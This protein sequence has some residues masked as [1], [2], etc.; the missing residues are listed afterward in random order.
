MKKLNNFTM[1][2]PDR[3]PDGRIRMTVL[4]ALLTLSSFWG[5]A[6]TTFTNSGNI[7]VPSSGNANPYPSNI[8]V[9]GMSGIIIDVKVVLTN[10]SHTNPTDLDIV[11]QSPT[12][13]NVVLMSDCMGSSDIS[14]R[15]YTFSDAA[16]S[17]LSTFLSSSSGTYRPTN[18]GSSDNWP[19]PGPGTITQ[20][21][22]VLSSFDGVAANGTWK[23]FVYD[24]N[25]S[26][27]GSI[28][29]GWSVIITTCVPPSPVA[30]NNGPIC[31]GSNLNLS[32]TGSGTYSWSGPNGFTSSSQNPVISSATSAATGTYTVTV[33]S[34]GCSAS[35][36]TSATVNSGTS[37]S[38]PTASASS[39]CSGN[40]ILICLQTEV[41][42]KLVQTQEIALQFLT[43][44]LRDIISNYRFR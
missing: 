26:N 39:V 7:S 3:K 19:S 22:P 18:S 4:I 1:I 36:T 30:S 28:S 9:S 40:Q 31:A 10:V 38:A 6:Q 16:S 17:N 32:T 24:D 5:F 11:A 44:T 34:G 12:G 13:V 23:L 33:T 35:T 25:N 29:G 27:S 43:I 14:N 42:L 2:L 37:G 41:F 8:S 15:T 20:G 21:T